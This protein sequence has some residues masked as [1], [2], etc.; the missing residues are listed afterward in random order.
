[1]VAICMFIKT[2]IRDF[3]ACSISCYWRFLSLKQQ[4]IGKNGKYFQP[5]YRFF[6]FPFSCHFISHTPASVFLL[7]CKLSVGGNFVST[8]N[9]SNQLKSTTY[10]RVFQKGCCH[11]HH[12]KDKLR[13]GVQGVK[14][15]NLN[16]PLSGQ[17][18]CSWHV[19]HSQERRQSERGFAHHVATIFHH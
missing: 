5:N 2:V 13:V 1:M 17:N 16:G 6:P 10:E 19:F 9:I 18:A 12:L 14:Y 11:S 4:M 15:L 8:F 3:H 7:L